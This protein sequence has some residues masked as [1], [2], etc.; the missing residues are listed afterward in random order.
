MV[1]DD[2]TGNVAEGRTAVRPFFIVCV[3]FPPNIRDDCG[4]VIAHLRFTGTVG[5]FPC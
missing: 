4:L 5:L 3:W 2:A 1:N